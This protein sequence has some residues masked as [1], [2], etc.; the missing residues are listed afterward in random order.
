VLKIVH[1]HLKNPII[2]TPML[3]EVYLL[4]IMN[5]DYILE[6]SMLGR[7]LLWV[8]SSILKKVSMIWIITPKP[9]LHS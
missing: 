8:G 7:T 5:I 6:N 2:N 3:L 9:Q 1:L 4:Q